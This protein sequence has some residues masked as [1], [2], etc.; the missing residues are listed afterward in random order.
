MLQR[1]FLMF[2]G[3]SE[4][5]P[6]LFLETLPTL[7]A[8]VFQWVWGFYKVQFYNLGLRVYVG[9]QPN[10][11]GLQYYVLNPKSILLVYLRSDRELSGRLSRHSGTDCLASG[12]ETAIICNN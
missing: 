10:Q 1:I 11:T 2:S 12:E 9:W 5:L 8:D 4:P 6:S 7:F 3:V